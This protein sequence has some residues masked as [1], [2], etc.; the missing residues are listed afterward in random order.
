[1]G[2]RFRFLPQSR[3]ANASNHLRCLLLVIFM[4]GSIDTFSSSQSF[5]RKIGVAPRAPTALR[6]KPQGQ[7]PAPWDTGHSLTPKRETSTFLG[8]FPNIYKKA[9]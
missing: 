1:M 2:A 6:A 4:K 3:V 5:I 7:C 9:F 8:A